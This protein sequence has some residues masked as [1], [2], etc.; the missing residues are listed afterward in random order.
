[1]IYVLFQK[2][3]WFSIFGRS[4]FPD[5]SPQNFFSCI[6]LL[7]QGGYKSLPDSVADSR[8]ESRA[9]CKKILLV[10]VSCS[11]RSSLFFDL[12]QS[13]L[14]FRLFVAQY[15]SLSL[16]LSFSKSCAR[17]GSMSV[18]E[19]TPSLSNRQPRFNVEETWKR[20]NGFVEEERIRRITSPVSFATHIVAV[21]VERKRES[22]P[23]FLF[24]SHLRFHDCIIPRYRIHGRRLKAP[25]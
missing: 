10:R 24:L 20:K 11:I 9:E 15:L 1:M 5:I 8:D 12:L 2:E 4:L 6:Q 22:V 7:S 17:A 16:S 19:F 13:H 18:P 14:S 23:R 21:N 25:S 3:F